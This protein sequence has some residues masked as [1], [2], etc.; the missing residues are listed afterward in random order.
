MSTS[1]LYHA[2]GVRC[3]Q[4]QRTDYAEGEV[5][6]RIRQ[7]RGA[8]WYVVCGSGH[9]LARGQQLWG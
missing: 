4:Y 9:G 5:I 6:M 7:T 8:E 1:L 2:F 3:Y